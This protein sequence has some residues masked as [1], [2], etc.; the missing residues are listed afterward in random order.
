MNYIAP[1]ILAAR[2]FDNGNWTD[3]LVVVVLAVF[4]AVGGILKAKSKARAAKLREQNQQQPSRKGRLVPSA[5]AGSRPQQ[6]QPRPLIQ[7]PH[8]K[9][10][11][12]VPAA[13]RLT[14]KQQQTARLQDIEQLVQSKLLS[15]VAPL[16]TGI[17][18]PF[19]SV[20]KPL[21]KLESKVLGLSGEMAQAVPAA[22]PKLVLDFGD[23]DELRRA[24]LHYEILG[25]PISL[26]DRSEQIIGF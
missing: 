26:R 13:A 20:G 1:I 8:R 21:K 4:W 12:P 15:P 23:P 2:K 10:A 17:K 7:P 6:M 16:Q 11:R 22:E 14:A 19:E 25:K 9:V 18:E 5:S 3:I 24:V